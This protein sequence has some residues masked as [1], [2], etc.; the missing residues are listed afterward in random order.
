ML[1]RI[2]VNKVSLHIIGLST[3][4]VG[5]QLGSF[6]FI[7]RILIFKV[8]SVF[9]VAGIVRV[10]GF[11]LNDFQDLREAFFIFFNGDDSEFVCALS[12]DH[13]R[14]VK[15]KFEDDECD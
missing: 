11:L 3:L 14:E 2:L 15:N 6:D 4:L 7:D 1:M 9:W 12:F 8:T 5:F 10:F 13:G